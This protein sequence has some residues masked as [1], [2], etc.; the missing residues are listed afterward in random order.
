[1]TEVDMEIPYVQGGAK[2]PTSLT[3]VGWRGRHVQ[4]QERPTKAELQQGVDRGMDGV[5][6][7]GKV[8]TQKKLLCLRREGEG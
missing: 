8:K 1:M 7:L 6:M 4:Y 2:E 3:G 5:E